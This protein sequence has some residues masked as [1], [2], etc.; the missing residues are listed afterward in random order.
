MHVV[1]ENQIIHEWPSLQNWAFK[2]FS[3]WAKCKKK[4]S[5]WFNQIVIM[6]HAIENEEHC[7]GGI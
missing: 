6:E 5:Q 1:S 2:S 7:S 4:C 3:K